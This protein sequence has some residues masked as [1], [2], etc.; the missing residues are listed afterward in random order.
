M[1]VFLIYDFFCRLEAIDKDAYTAFQ[2]S[3]DLEAVIQRCLGAPSSSNSDKTS[4]SDSKKDSIKKKVALTV[5][6]P[7]LPMLVSL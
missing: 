3:N 2:V 7:V 5:M 4:A 6:T 1:K